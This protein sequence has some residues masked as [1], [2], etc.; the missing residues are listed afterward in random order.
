V[1]AGAE[2]QLK[3]MIDHLIATAQPDSDLLQELEMSDQ[4]G[5]TSVVVER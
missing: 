3:D 1:K 5:P 4:R 2:A